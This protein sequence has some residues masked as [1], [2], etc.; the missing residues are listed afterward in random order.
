MP[1]EFEKMAWQL[2]VGEMAPVETKMGWHL[3]LRRG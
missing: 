3:I 2:K 1:P